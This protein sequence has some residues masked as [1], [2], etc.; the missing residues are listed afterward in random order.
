MAQ[1]VSVDQMFWQGS[2]YR[3]IFY[4]SVILILIFEK[5]IT[6]KIV[7]SFFP[8]LMT[9][10]LFNPVTS[11]LV[12]LFFSKPNLYYVR[13]FSVIPILYCMAHAVTLMIKKTTGAVKLVLVCFSAVIIILTGHSIYQ[14]SWMEWAENMEK[15]PTEALKVVEAIPREKA[16]VCVAF[17]DPLYLY[18]RQID[19]SIQMPYGRDLSG[20]SNPLLNE[21]DNPVPDPLAV[22]TQAGNAAVDY[23]VVNKSDDA[24]ACFANSG[25]LPAAETDQYC[26]YPVTGV[27]RKVLEYNDKRQIIS[28]TS[29]DAQGNPTYS[30]NRVITRYVIENDRFGND[31]KTEYYDRNNDRVTC[32]DGYAGVRKQFRLVGLSWAVDSEAY[33]DALDQ[34]VLIWGRYVTKYDYNRFKQVVRESYYNIDGQPMKRLDTGYAAVLKRYDNKN[35]LFSEQYVDERGNP[36]TSSEGYASYVRRFDDQD[37]CIAEEYFDPDGNIVRNKNGFAGFTR[38]YSKEG[39]VREEIYIDENS[40]AIDI[41]SLIDRNDSR[42]LLQRLEKRSVE[43]AVGIC[44]QWDDDGSCHV[45]GKSEGITW[46]SL[47][48]GDR[49]YFLRNGADYRIE[50]ASENVVLRIYFYEDLKMQNLIESLA[51]KGNDKFTVPRNCSAMI[52]R[53][54]VAAGVEVD[55]TVCPQILEVT[56]SKQ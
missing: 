28:N 45:S 23:V 16:N 53:L 39:A 26:I 47:I 34:P 6:Y 51:V 20:N 9:V 22:M 38:A 37:R 7:F 48:E 17:P 2:F 56:S 13:L 25:H 50:Y 29:C 33:L 15:V 4:A 5:R 27:E 52:M 46:N 3:Y 54:W 36:V 49:P 11:V 32:V 41:Q 40:Y 31:I 24:M 55:E 19:A 35:R 8:L 30:A 18:V 21:L 10:G 44:Y 43:D 14:E 42:N 1:F 12:A